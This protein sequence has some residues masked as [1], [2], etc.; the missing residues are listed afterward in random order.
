MVIL[1]ICRNCF[2]KFDRVTKRQTLCSDC[3]AKIFAE[4]H[5]KIKQ[6]YAIMLANKSILKN[7]HLINRVLLNIRERGF[8]KKCH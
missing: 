4:S 7:H 1:K 2:K 6:T 8:N 5:R 3:K